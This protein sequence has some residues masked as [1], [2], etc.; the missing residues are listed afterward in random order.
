MLTVPQ[1]LDARRSSGRLPSSAFVQPHR[2]LAELERERRQTS[3]PPS[4]T[5][6]HQASHTPPQDARAHSPAM[7]R[8][9]LRGESNPTRVGWQV[10]VEVP[11]PTQSDSDTQVSGGSWF[12]PLLW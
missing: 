1:P 12:Y 4:R 8:S 10:P 6:Q 2:S 11:E 7:F 3:L 9:L 5:V